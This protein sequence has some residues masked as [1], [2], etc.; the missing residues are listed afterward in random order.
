MSV[1]DEISNVFKDKVK[2][3]TDKFGEVWIETGIDSLK[4]ILKYLNEKLRFDHLSTI[5]GYD[6]GEEIAIIYHLLRF[7]K[8]RA[9]KVNVRVY[10]NRDNPSVPSITEIYPS[11]L[12]YER[13][14]YD[15]LGVKFEGHPNLKR[16]LLPEDVPEG[17]HPLRKDFKL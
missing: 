14:V 10:T 2:C 12:I 1:C 13:E 9:E 11:A 7:G 4:D 17:F 8:G 15:L 3:F 5:T 6:T 16:L